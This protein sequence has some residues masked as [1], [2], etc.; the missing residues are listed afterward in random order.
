MELVP[1]DAR[2]AVPTN[3][4]TRSSNGPEMLPHMTRLAVACLSAVLA[5]GL[6][7]CGDDESSTTESEST[8]SA[9]STTASP[10][11]EPAT[12]AMCAARDDLKSAVDDT[13]A[14]AR[15]GDLAAVRDGVTALRS[16]AEALRSTLAMLA[17]DQR[18]ALQP[19][20]DRVETAWQAVRAARRPSELRTAV[21][22]LGTE[23]DALADAASDSLDCG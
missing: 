8:P 5:L 20:V 16:R 7:G 10:T 3:R 14:A 4:V 12:E 21:E 11:A 15:D 6:A 17:E 1:V 13:V 9:S 19:E 22:T 2:Q 23:V 18:V